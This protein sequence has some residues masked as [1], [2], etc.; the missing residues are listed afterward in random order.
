MTSESQERMLA[1]VT[2]ANLDAVLELCGR[3]EIRATVDRTRHRHRALPRVRRAL[4]RGRRARREPAARRAATTRPT[5]RPTAARSPTCP[6]RAWA[7][8]RCTTGPARRPPS[9]TRAARRRSRAGARGSAS[10]TGTDL[11]DELLALLAA[12][13]IADKSWVYRQ[14]DHQLFLNTVV[15]PGGDAAVLRLKGTAHA[16]ALTTDGKARF[17]ALDPHIGRT[18][19]RDRGGAQP[20]VRR[21]GAQGARELPQ[22]R[23]PRASRGDV[24][25]LRGRRRHE[26]RRAARSTSPSSAAT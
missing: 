15:G 26:P 7:T 2:P 22:L 1:I 5:C 14:Y 25:V 12:P 13:T 17:C 20:R 10:P 21:R 8:A 16:L 23:Q 4:R 9:S 19:R 18:P 6:S 3:W 11:S 24:A